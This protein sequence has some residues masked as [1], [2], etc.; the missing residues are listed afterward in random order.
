MDSLVNPPEATSGLQRLAIAIIFVFA[1]LALVI[2]VLRAVGRIR[3]RQFGLD[4]WLIS[5]AMF[6][7]VLETIFSYFFIKTNYVG[8][9]PENV[10]PHDP[11]AGEV[12]NYL[13]QVFYNPILALAKSSV[14]IFLLRLFGQQNGTRRLIH[15]L[16]AVNLLHMA[17]SL[18]AIT[19]QCTPVSLAWNPGSSSSRGGR[20]VDRAVLFTA[21]ATFNIATDLVVLGLPLWILSGLQ[22]PRRTK[23]ALLG[24]FLLGFLVTITS[25][26]RLVILV[27]GLFG[28]SAAGRTGDI[29]F[30]TSAIETNLALVTASAPALRPLLR[31]RGRGRGGWLPM[32]GRAADV[33]MGQPTTATQG[34]RGGR[35]VGRPVVVVVREPQGSRGE[36]EQQT[37]TSNSNSNSNSNASGGGGDSTM[38]VSDVQREID[39]LVKEMELARAALG[40]S[41]G[42][43]RGTGGPGAAP[44]MGG[45]VGE[46][47]RQQQTK[48]QQPRRN[49][50]EERMSRYGDRRFGLVHASPAMP[51]PDKASG[52]RFF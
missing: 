32:A 52:P 10:P 24:V 23:L 28:L 45:A 25:V 44:M 22:I 48:R 5:V 12:W 27:R 35:G 26:A 38:R 40:S 2:I 14:L 41:G 13:V 33:E 51:G 19:F 50:A 31:G 30:V 39:R 6:L 9:R 16:N 1:A 42:A 18:G 43:G 20:C 47:R 15:W 46:Q 11:V 34:G 21:M 7:S 29:G 37:M 36:K 8:I 4:D 49:Y 3:T 17:A